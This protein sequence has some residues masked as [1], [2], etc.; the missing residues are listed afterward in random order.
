M[1]DGGVQCWGANDYGQLG[2]VSTTGSAYP[3]NV[4]ARGILAGAEGAGSACC[5]FVLGG[6]MSGFIQA[7]LP[8]CYLSDVASV[9]AGGEHTCAVLVDT[10]AVCWGYNQ[11]GE[12]GNGM[13]FDS[14]RPVDVCGPFS[15][16]AGIASCCPILLAGGIGPPCTPLS[17]AGAIDAGYRHSCA[18]MTDGSLLCWGVGFSGQL[19]TGG[20]FDTSVPIAVCD[21][22][23]PLAGVLPICPPLSGVTSAGAGYS[24]TCALMDDK[25]PLCWGP[26]LYGE[27][28]NAAMTASSV[29]SE[30]VGFETKATPTPTATIAPVET[31]LPTPVE[32]TNTPTPSGGLPGDVNCDGSVDAIDAAFILQLVADLIEAVPCPQNADV[33]GD[34]D[35]D[36][37]DSALI[38]QYSAGL[39]PSL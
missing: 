23:A 24:H 26:N 38:L 37:I 18:V 29:P 20:S 21:A 12:L 13:N 19:G 6:T 35:I 31:S 5:P 3:V 14:T 9:S 2:N 1:N 27:L 32:P 8:G 30:V 11:H 17:G 4:C 28:G 22:A 7:P 33:N 16:S 15:L 39:I 36:P 34:G 25:R 10:S